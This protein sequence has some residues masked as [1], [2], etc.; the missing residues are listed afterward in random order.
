MNKECIYING[1]VLVEDE[2]RKKKEVQYQDNIEEVLYQENVIESIKNKRKELIY[3]KAEINLKLKKKSNN[4][5]RTIL[6]SSSI[7]SAVIIPQT[8]LNT[9]AL[10]GAFQAKDVVTIALLIAAITFNVCDIASE[11][12]EKENLKNETSAITCELEFL[13]KQLVKEKEKLEELNNNKT[14]ENMPEGLKISEI[15][16]R[17]LLESIK[18]NLELHYNLGYNLEKYYEYL[19]DGILEEKINEEYSQSDVE[20]A[21]EFLEEKGFMLTRRK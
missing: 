1:N 5:F 4:F 17:N 20:D 10:I 11:K 3:K 21:I 9:A 13:Y 2:N 18:H 14:K 19:E 7:I 12:K 6:I 16:D 15:N 8:M